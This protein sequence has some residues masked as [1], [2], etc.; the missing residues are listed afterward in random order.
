MTKKLLTSKLWAVI[1]LLIIVVVIIATFKM[2]T[3][4]WSYFD[5]FFAFMAAFCHFMATLFKKII[6][7]ESRRLELIALGM[8][9][10]MVISVIG[11]LIAI[12][13]IN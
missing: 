9:G 3:E 1:Y 8:V 13:F 4:W 6:P 7:A 11:E 12:S 5:I 10:L 2:R